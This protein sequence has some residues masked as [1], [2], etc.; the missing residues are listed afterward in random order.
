MIFDGLVLVSAPAL[1]LFNFISYS[2]H[3]RASVW[4]KA[5]IVALSLAAL[6]LFSVALERLWSDPS[7][8]RGT[9]MLMAAV[10]SLVFLLLP[11]VAPTL[12]GL[13]RRR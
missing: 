2:P 8:M 5:H 4:V 12:M 1:W 9:F 13:L 7:G 11:L 6:I 10:V 3:E